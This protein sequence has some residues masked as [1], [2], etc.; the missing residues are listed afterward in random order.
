MKIFFKKTHA[1]DI[2]IYRKF[3]IVFDDI[4]TI[5]YVD[6]DVDISISTSIYRFD[7]ISSHHYS[8]LHV[9]IKQSKI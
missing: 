1:K 4:D 3:D 8:G 6:I 9:G 7:D 5:R 2:A